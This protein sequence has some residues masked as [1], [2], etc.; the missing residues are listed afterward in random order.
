MGS[1]RAYYAGCGVPARG[2]QRHTA[3]DSSADRKDAPLVGCVY[4]KPRPFDL[5]TE[6]LN[7]GDNGRADFS[8]LEPGCL[9][10][11]VQEPA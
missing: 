7:V 11:Q 3:C 4:R 9:A 1:L 2:G 8:L 6:S 10:L 5:V